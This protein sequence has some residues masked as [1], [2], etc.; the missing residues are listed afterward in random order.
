MVK[1]WVDKWGIAKIDL[2]TKLNKPK[3]SP[4]SCEVEKYGQR[5]LVWADEQSLPTCEKYNLLVNLTAV[6]LSQ[7]CV[8][9]GYISLHE[10]NELGTHTFVFKPDHIEVNTAQKAMS[11]RRVWERLL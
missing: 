11:T 8:N 5:I 7:L 10:L 4:K 6:N 2:L 1:T 3:C 9:H